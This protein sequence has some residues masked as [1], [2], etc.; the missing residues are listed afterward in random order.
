[1]TCSEFSAT[2]LESEGIQTKR[3]RASCHK[4][5]FPFNFLTPGVGREEEG[6]SE[7]GKWRGLI[8]YARNVRWTL[9]GANAWHLLIADNFGLHSARA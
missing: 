4:P 2:V 3:T 6:P 1:M 5:H 7:N 9:P 8:K